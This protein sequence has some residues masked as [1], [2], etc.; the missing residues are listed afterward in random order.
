M[1]IILYL[2]E[3]NGAAKRVSA[4]CDIINFSACC[5]GCEGR[6]FGIKQQEMTGVKAEDIIGKDDY[7]LPIPFLVIKPMLSRY[8]N[9]RID[10]CS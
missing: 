10:L 3:K 1:G 2:N 4:D 8:C 7:R 9:E 5:S 6:L